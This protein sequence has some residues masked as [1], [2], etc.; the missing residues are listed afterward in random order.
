MVNITYQ[1]Q[2][3]IQLHKGSHFLIQSF[4]EPCFL[5]KMSTQGLISGVELVIR[6]TKGD[7]KT[8]WVMFDHIK[9][10]HDWTTMGAY[11]YHP[12]GCCLMTIALCEMKVED[13]KSQ[14]LF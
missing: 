5:F 9:K 12:F 11:V 6:M 3:C 14:S 1:M 10:M 13:L 2:Q 7:L 4:D 8:S